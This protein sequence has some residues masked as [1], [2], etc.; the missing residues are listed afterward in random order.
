VLVK[1]PFL[2]LSAWKFDCLKKSN[3]AG[4]F[5]ALP[6]IWL[7]FPEITPEAGIARRC[8]NRIDTLLHLQKFTEP[9]A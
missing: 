1:G 9:A 5:L 2:F 3:Q 8:Q 4:E 6:V 7:L